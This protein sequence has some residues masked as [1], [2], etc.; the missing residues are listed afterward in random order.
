[1][2][3]SYKNANELN[4][5][6]DTRLPQH[7]SFKRYEVVVAGE[8]FELYA[9]NIVECLKALWADPDFLPF[10]VFEPEKHYGDDDRTIRLF[11]DMHTGKWWWATQVWVCILYIDAIVTNYNSISSDKSNARQEKRASPSFL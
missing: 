6:I 8:S 2:K 3:L 1:L 7:P 9:R 4:K 10:L 5:I 11:H